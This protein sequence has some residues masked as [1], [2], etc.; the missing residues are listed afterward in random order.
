M[1]WNV[2]FWLYLT[3]IFFAIDIFLNF[4][5]AYPAS[6]NDV[7]MLTATIG[8]HSHPPNGPGQMGNNNQY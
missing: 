1:A 6:I 7:D 2:R 3:T 8:T 5:T 4:M